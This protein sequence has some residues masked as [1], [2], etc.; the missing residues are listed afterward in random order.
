MTTS[1]AIDPEHPYAEHLCLHSNPLTEHCQECY[2]ACPD[3]WLALWA[4]G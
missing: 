3:L 2:D 4:G 1:T